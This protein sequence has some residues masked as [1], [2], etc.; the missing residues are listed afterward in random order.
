V[1]VTSPLPS[2]SH[3]FSGANLNSNNSASCPPIIGNYTNHTT[4]YGSTPNYYWSFGDGNHSTL[5]NP[6]NIFVFAGTYNLSLIVTDQFGCKDSIS[7]DHLTISGPSITPSIITT[8]NPCDNAFIFD[9]TNAVDIDHF[10]WELGDGTTTSSLSTTHNYPNQGNYITTLHIFDKNNCEIKYY[11]TLNIISNQINANFTATP[12]TAPM[13]TQIIFDDQST[14]NTTIQSWHWFYGDFNNTDQINITD[15]NT[16]F[17]YDLPYLYPVTLVVTDF[18]GCSDTT[19]I[20]V[21][22]TGDIEVPNVF[23]PNGD[24]VNDIFQFSQNIF[25]SYD[26][27]ILNRWGNV[28]FENKNVIGTYIWNGKDMKLNECT[29][30]VYYYIIK[31]LFKDETPFEKNGFLSLFSSK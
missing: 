7:Y 29:D 27:I 19:T 26:V 9:T 24:G 30:G 28:V 20:I 3:I 11:D 18:N 8:S 21:H 16:S 12:A 6:Q 13:G 25:K 15:T 10:Y 31:G 14:F 1:K 22:I 23:T 17:I 4:Y 2:E 5:V